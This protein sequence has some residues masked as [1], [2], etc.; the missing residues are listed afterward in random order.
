MRSV[1]PYGAV[2]I[3]R[4]TS[5]VRPAHIAAWVGLVAECLRCDLNP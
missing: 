3:R 2:G 1:R 4:Q 5:A